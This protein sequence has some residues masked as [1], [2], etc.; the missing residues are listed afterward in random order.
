MCED[1]SAACNQARR[2]R[3]EEGLVARVRL[4][5]EMGRSSSIDKWITLNP[6]APGLAGWTQRAKRIVPWFGPGLALQWTQRR[7]GS[8]CYLI[9]VRAQNCPERACQVRRCNLGGAH[10]RGDAA[11][12]RGSAVLLWLIS[13]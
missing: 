4:Y 7:I 8:S 10:T 12:P 3:G 9:L 1:R 13:E 11:G 5:R 2:G 6:V